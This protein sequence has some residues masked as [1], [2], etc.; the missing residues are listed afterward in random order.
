M[1]GITVGIIGLGR[2][3]HAFGVS[4]VGDPLSHSEAFSRVP[5]VRLS[6]GLDPDA[7]RR[8]AFAER[9]PDATVCDGVEAAPPRTD[10]VVV[11][12]PTNAHRESIEMALGMHARVI[13]CEKPI[14][15]TVH[16]ARAIVERVHAAGSLLVVNYTRRFTPM[17]EHLRAETAADRTLAGPVTGCIRFTGGLVHNG[18]H[19]IDLCRA[20]FGDIRSV[21]QV[22]GARSI[23]GGGGPLEVTFSDDRSAVLVEVAGTAYSVGEGEFYGASGAVR[24]SDGGD[25]V[26]VSDA[27]ASGTWPGFRVLGRSRV[28]TEHGLRGH[29]ME[30]ARHAIAL[31]RDGG[32]PRCT[33]E[34]GIA[35][36]E[37]V[38]MATAV[39]A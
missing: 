7:A 5:A 4:P 33:G 27:A 20:V 29:M 30:L 32:T 36:L 1:T 9:F 14:A 38:Q 10:V 6:W 35:A 34:D 18:T 19:W 21:R 23:H 17:L 13:V 25:V 31:A 24:F 12:S 15:P 11:C 26:S 39:H 28:L 3:G 2:I 8:R 37:A 16:D 22:A